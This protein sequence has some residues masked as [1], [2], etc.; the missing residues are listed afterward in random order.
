MGR[1]DDSSKGGVIVGLSVPSAM[2]TPATSLAAPTP[3]LL[4]WAGLGV[5]LQKTQKRVAAGT[6]DLVNLSQPSLLQQAVK[7]VTT[8]KTLIGG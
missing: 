5:T 6:G 1:P 8:P 2:A 3:P 7:G 4:S